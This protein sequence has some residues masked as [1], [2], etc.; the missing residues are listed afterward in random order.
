MMYSYH[1]HI[2]DGGSDEVMKAFDGPSYFAWER[3]NFN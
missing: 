1:K 3:R 2:I